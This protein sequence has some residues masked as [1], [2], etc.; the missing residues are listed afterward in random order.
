M[1]PSPITALTARQLVD[2]FAA[3]AASIAA[4]PSTTDGLAA[5]TAAAAREIPGVDF[6]SISR[7]RGDHFQTL[8][9]TGPA[10]T[11]AD[12][13]Q[14]ELGSGPCVDAITDHTA[15]RTGDVRTD[16]R[17]PVYGPRTF[18]DYGVLSMLSIRLVLDDDDDVSASL[19]LYS[20]TRDAFTDDAD[21]IATLL[22]V[23]GATALSRLIARDR[24]TNLTTALAT[25]RH[26]GVAIG[27][28]VAVEKI[29]AD[30]A[31]DL[32]RITSQHANRKLTDIA[33]DVT[34]QGAL[35]SP[36]TTAAPVIRGTT[37]TLN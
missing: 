32:L 19:N 37:D 21:T 24:T 16:P 9:P 30:Q 11:G 33:T 25:A 6:A 12:R 7:H 36:P 1:A 31:F 5:I 26:I 35:P 18:T 10:A 13:L 17:W 29:T 14:Y 20:R 3:L 27:I 28:L 8:A 22:A 23:H 4:A 2:M 15:F 34:D